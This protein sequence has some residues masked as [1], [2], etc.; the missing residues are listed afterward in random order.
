MGMTG[1]QPQMIRDPHG[2]LTLDDLGRENI[3]EYPDALLIAH[4]ALS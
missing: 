4:A 2:P 3:N 1:A